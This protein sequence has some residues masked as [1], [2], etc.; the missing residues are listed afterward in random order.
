MT[1]ENPRDAQVEGGP[2]RDLISGVIGIMHR[3][4]GLD[5]SGFKTHFLA[6]FI[7]NRVAACHLPTPE[8][9]GDVLAEDPEEAIDFHASLRI[10]YTEFFRNPLI[11]G[12]LEEKILP[13]LIAAQKQAGR[14]ELRVWSAG[15]ATGQET[16]SIV[17]LLDELSRHWDP[18]SAYRVFAT[19]VCGKHL[20]FA[21]AGEYSN[22][23]VGNVRQ[24]HL[25]HYFLKIGD[26]HLIS[27]HLRKQVDFG[28]HDL[29]DKNAACPSASIFGDFDLIFCCNLLFY[30]RPEI[31]RQ[32]LEKFA[33]ALH[34]GG[35]L[36]TDDS[37]RGLPMGHHDLYPVLPNAPIFQ[38]FEQQ[39]HPGGPDRQHFN[40]FRHD[41]S[42][43]QTSAP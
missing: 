28:M 26:S 1:P 43:P 11:F 37:G 25:E 9:Y 38:K 22:K 35:Y 29:H 5:I 8:S 41:V 17:M 13:H 40:D 20:E 42:P 19:D 21:R 12:I 34:P 31:Q 18:P 15:C 16:W 6:K 14:R 10:S 33:R 7:A 4:H 39:A 36:V 32:I 24:R 3:V 2:T 27:P 23:A 30:Y